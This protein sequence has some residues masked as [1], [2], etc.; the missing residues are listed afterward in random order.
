MWCLTYVND[1]AD[2]IT[3]STLTHLKFEKVSCI[4]SLKNDVRVFLSHICQASA[5]YIQGD[6]GA[7]GGT[8]F[9]ITSKTFIVHSYEL[10]VV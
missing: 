8:L 4:M 7:K 2:A 6:S 10:R 9:I 3:V 5:K 1:V